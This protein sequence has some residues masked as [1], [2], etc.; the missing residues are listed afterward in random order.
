M[1]ID[2]WG[3]KDEECLVHKDI[4]DAIEEILDNHNH[5]WPETITV[6]GFERDK[7]SL[8]YLKG[9]LVDFALE[10]LDEDY[11]TSDAYGDGSESTP[12]MLEAEKVFI[13]AI[14]SEYTPYDCEITTEVV[15]PVTEWIENHRPE[16]LED[17]Q[18]PTCN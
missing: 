12:K 17:A 7:V 3:A 9:R 4:D 6:C 16:W 8:D 13:E 2:F 18:V 5:P 11:R 15:V 1:N 14:V 10:E